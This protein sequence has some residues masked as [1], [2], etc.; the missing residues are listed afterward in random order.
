MLAA[1]LFLT[2]VCFFISNISDIK[3]PEWYRT[4]DIEN[5][6]ELVNKSSHNKGL[7]KASATRIMENNEMLL[8]IIRD[9]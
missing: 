7:E 2:L 1:E 5:V 6:Y 8:Y 3:D 9:T 4:N